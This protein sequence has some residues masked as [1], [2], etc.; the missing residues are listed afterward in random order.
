MVHPSGDP[1]SFFMERGYWVEPN[2]ISGFMLERLR[3]HYDA[4]CERALAKGGMRDVL[5]NDPEHQN[6][7]GHY[8]ALHDDGLLSFE[9]EEELLRPLR[10][11]LGP[12]LKLV[13]EAAF[14]KPAQ[15][16][17][18]TDWHQDSAYH[19]VAAPHI[20][21]GCWIAL[22][23]ATLQSGCMRVI[24]GSHLQEHSHAHDAATDKRKRVVDMKEDQAVAVELEPGGALLFDFRTLHMTGRNTST[25][26]RRAW[27]LH[28]APTESTI[29]GDHWNTRDASFRPVLCGEGATGGMNEFGRAISGL[30]RQ[31]A[32]QA[33][34]GL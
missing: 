32:G 10:R 30:W 20:G 2:L 8:V 24:P 23:K 28:V 7:Q 33:G 14:T 25:A 6:L 13:F 9:F 17:G 29:V 18:I 12:N 11:L 3:V 15:S 16:G 19:A 1:V 34:S 22:D 4:A 26:I 21:V 27:A 5:E 31:L